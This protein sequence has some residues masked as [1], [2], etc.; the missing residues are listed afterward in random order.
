MFDVPNRIGSSGFPNT[1]N[2]HPYTFRHNI[3]S[4]Y[5]NTR[6]ET[7]KLPITI[8]PFLPFLSHP[9]KP[10]LF[11]LLSIECREFDRS[12]PPSPAFD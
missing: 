12:N 6:L 2:H 5:E 10:V 9:D 11:S 4:K 7:L 8:L 1:V 3:L